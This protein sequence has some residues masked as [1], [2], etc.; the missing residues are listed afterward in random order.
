MHRAVSS[1]SILKYKVYN[2]SLELWLNKLFRTVILSHPH[3]HP[4][5]SEIPR[6]IWRTVNFLF[7]IIITDCTGIKQFNLEKLHIQ[8]YHN[9]THSSQQIITDEKLYYFTIY[10]TENTY[11]STVH[12][13][14]FFFSTYLIL[15]LK[16]STNNTPTRW[17][18]YQPIKNILP[19]YPEMYITY[20]K[21]TVQENIPAIIY[22]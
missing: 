2:N 1:S 12:N 6:E 13:N 15:L 9:H 7:F 5:N 11:H 17:D 8:A 10:K 20:E 22:R 16:T 4:P 3:P 18:R 19:S 14:Q 21:I